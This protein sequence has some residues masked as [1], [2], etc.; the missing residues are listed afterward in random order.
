MKTLSKVILAGAAI[1]AIKGLDNR[2]EITH[3]TA[4]SNKLPK[5]F[6]KF[7]ICLFSDLHN[8]TTAGL[9]DAVRGENPDIICLQEVKAKEEDLFLY[10]SV[11]LILLLFISP[12]V[13]TM[14]GEVI[15]M[16]LFY[17]AKIKVQ[18]F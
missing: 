6:D 5:E 16:T 3:Y 13:I 2:L 18:Y 15:T 11:L 14:Y 9:S 17:V 8:D 7:K 10:L 4:K 12:Q 1:A